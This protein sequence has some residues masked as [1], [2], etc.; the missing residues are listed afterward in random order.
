MLRM[1]K[2]FRPT[3]SWECDYK[4]ML[5]L[6]GKKYPTDLT[7]PS[8]PSIKFREEFALI[9]QVFLFLQYDISPL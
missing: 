7:L 2:K 3:R 8:L 9:A 4:S 6:A 5:G 1:D